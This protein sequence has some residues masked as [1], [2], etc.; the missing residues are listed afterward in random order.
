MCIYV[1]SLCLLMASSLALLCLCHIIAQENNA[2]LQ[3]EI[4]SCK[5]QPACN[6]HEN[7]KHTCNSLSLCAV[8][9][10][11]RNQLL[12]LLQQHLDEIKSEKYASIFTTCIRPYDI[13]SSVFT[14]SKRMAAISRIHCKCEKD[15]LLGCFNVYT[16]TTMSCIW[17]H[18]SCAY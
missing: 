18:G 5:G 16:Y 12:H 7:T 1:T 14:Y 15:G 2:A 11:E 3:A 9:I 8:V 13:L 4:T 6:I 17:Q 10:D